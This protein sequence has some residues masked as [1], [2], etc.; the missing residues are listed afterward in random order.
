MSTF[1][2]VSFAFCVLKLG[3]RSHTHLDCDVF[4][5]INPLPLCIV[6]LYFW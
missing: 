2:L 1:S 5:S 3:V 6:S 4:L